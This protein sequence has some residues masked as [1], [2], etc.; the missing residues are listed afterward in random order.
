MPV[1]GSKFIEYMEFIKLWRLGF[2]ERVHHDEL[3]H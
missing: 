3:A 2:T 1:H